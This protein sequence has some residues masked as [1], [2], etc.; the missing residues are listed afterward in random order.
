MPSAM[1]PIELD[2]ERAP[3]PGPRHRPPSGRTRVWLLGGA[4][5]VVLALVA[6]QWAADAW[7]RARWERLSDR[8]EVVAPVDRSLTVRWSLG[9]STFVS[10]SQGVAWRGTVVGPL[11]GADGSIGVVELDGRDGHVRWTRSVIGPDTARSAK[12]GALRP[13]G[14][15]ERVPDDAS[16]IVCLLT[17]AVVVTAGPSVSTSQATQAHLVVLDPR[18]G[19]VRA[20]HAIA[21]DLSHLG[22]VLRSGLAVLVSSTRHQVVG[23]DTG[24]GVERWRTAPS[25]L[26]DGSGHGVVRVGELV[27]VAGDTALDLLGPDGK[28][29][30]SVGLRGYAGAQ[31][32]A[33]GRLVLPDAAGTLVVGPDRDLHLD[34]VP[35]G[36]ASDDGSLPG[37]TLLRS[38]V[39]RAFDPDGR[40][41]WQLP[42]ASPAGVVV[43]GGVVYVT[44]DGGV[45]A[46]DGSTGAVRWQA[47]L[48][49]QQ[50]P[51]V[52]D[53]R[54]L[55]VALGTD[56]AALDLRTGAV[57]WR[58]PL[59]AGHPRLLGFDGLLLAI[60]QDGSDFVVIG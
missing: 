45:T 42:G 7:A 1:V 52:T 48:P 14:S 41:L 10:V 37:L 47:A 28:V 49:V 20:S 17:D 53:G 25:V 44:R 39:L 4:A 21:A 22:V 59:P 3:A 58:A 40:Q 31:P 2:D 16:R 26:Q 23:V 35:V 24:S 9:P 57:L 15:C 60:A 43:L 33:D 32:L 5:A 19:S 46:V 51:P 36:I 6:G 8:T 55:I 12:E 27:A 38:G 50:L 13:T 30:R 29:R 11:L 18:N 34:G 54:V 56:V